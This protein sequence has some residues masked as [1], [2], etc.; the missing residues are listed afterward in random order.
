MKIRN[1][2]KKLSVV[3]GVTCSFLTFGLTNANADV[4]KGQGG[5]APKPSRPVMRVAAGCEAPTSQIELDINNVRARLMNGGDMWWDI[6]GSRNA[7]YEVPKAEAGARSIHSSFASG[8]WFGGVD[9]GGQLKTAGQTYRQTG[10]DFWSGP[11]DTLTADISAEDC[12]DW[13]KMYSVTREDINKSASGSIEAT[14]AAWR[15]NGDQAK[16]QAQFMAPFVDVDGDGVYN[17]SLGDYPT[18]DPSEP[19][20]K[21]DQMIWWVYNDKGNTHTAYPGGEPIGL[22]VHALAFAFKSAA[23][24]NNMTFYK[25]RIFN[26]ASSPLYDTYMGVFTDSDLGNAADDYVGCNMALIDP[27]GPSGP[28]PAKRRS[29]GYTYN[30][31][32]NDEDTGSPGYGV[33]PPVFGI[34]YFRGPKDSAGVEIPMTTFMFFTNAGVPG[35]TSDPRNAVELYRYLQ[36]F[37][38][39][40]QELTYGTATGRG[41]SDPCKFA[42]PGTT[43]PDGRAN[44]VET[45]APGDRRMVQSSGPFVLGAGAVNEVIIGAVWARDPAEGDNLASITAA[46]A[47]DD[48]AQVLFDNNFKLANG[49]EPITLVAVPGD[50]KVTLSIT[51][52]EKAE[53]YNINELDDQDLVL[54]RYKFQGY[55]IYQLK[56]NTVSASQI[57]DPT[58]AVEIFQ[59]DIKD[60]IDKIIN[61]AFDPI[62]SN[63]NAFVAIEGENKGLQHVFE[64][65]TDKFSSSFDATL[66]NGKTYYFLCIPYANTTTST[67]TKYLPSRTATTVVATVPNKQVV[68]GLVNGT[69]EPFMQVTKFDGRGN[70]GAYL[71]ITPES[72]AAILATN[73]TSPVKYEFGAGPVDIRV[74]DP[75]K[76]KNN[77]RN[78]RLQFTNDLKSYTLYDADSGEELMKSDTTYDPT[79]TL[80]ENEQIAEKRVFA[81]NPNGTLRLV[82]REPLGFVIKAQSNLPAI[83]SVDAQKFYNNN[84]LGAEIV[85]TNPDNQ[86]LSAIPGSRANTTPTVGGWIEENTVIDSLSVYT[87]ILGGTWAPYKFARTNN[88]DNVSRTTPLLDAGSKSNANSRFDSI[89]SYDIVFTSDTTKWSECV[90]LE[91]GLTSIS[92]GEPATEGNQKRFNIRKGNIGYGV[93]RSKFPGYAINVESGERVN[94]FFAEASSYPDENGADMKWNP[95]SNTDFFKRG[96]RHFIYVSRRK[97]DSCNEIYNLL[98][99]NGTNIDNP[100]NTARRS[101]MSMIDWVTVPVL[102]SGKTLLSSDVRVK[103]RVAKPYLADVITNNN[104]GVPYFTFNSLN[105]LKNADSD[106]AKSK[107]A[108]LD[109]INVVPNPYY[110]FSAY[111]QD[112]NDNRVRFTNLPAEAKITIYTTN[113]MLVTRLSKSDEATPYIEWDLRNSS[114]IPIASGVYII[115]VN[116][117]GI[118]ERSLKWMAVMR[119]IDF[120]NF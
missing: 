75:S 10:L 8:L 83:G 47:A 48:K 73:S 82:S 71:N 44:W 28:L 4:W 119:P 108:A 84:F 99:V 100:P 20:A 64:V 101:I 62:T 26:R 19:G 58:K 67:Y 97:Y 72:E 3:L 87:N 79:N 50:R 39:D 56:D 36:G 77:K 118:G 90:V 110:A 21:P 45:D 70:G 46:V 98:T 95:T 24:I 92:F 91:S 32:N 107:E 37:W 22:E 116:C 30:A 14:V 9:E 15:G 54:H 112:R 25:Y 102:A 59:V 34:D 78:Y 117:P 23:E 11:L 103:L 60:D 55:R 51:D 42:F 114:R 17:P 115:H 35:Q 63:E 94:I 68:N 106:L 52:Y 38:A 12:S 89:G 105:T 53:R 31:D 18:L 29:F 113:G 43:D 81:T 16:G 76:I 61:K 104:G 96:G 66:I 85:Y 5:I 6:F 49:P 93:G 80:T 40:N 120:T 41:G 74:Y 27:D 88:N 109:L 7:A 2:I 57:N 86:W 33:G 111:E 13:D 65:N 69:F 1:D